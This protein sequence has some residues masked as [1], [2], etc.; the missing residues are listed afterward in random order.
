[1]HALSQQ[2]FM[3]LARKV[4]LRRHALQ[5][6]LVPYKKGSATI[7]LLFNSS[8]GQSTCAKSSRWY[9][10]IK[11]HMICGY[12]S[13][14]Q[15]PTQP[16][17]SMITTSESTYKNSAFASITT[18]TVDQDGILLEPCLSSIGDFNV[19]TRKISY[20]RLAFQKVLSA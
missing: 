15:P 3:G 16:R 10:C 14:A 2:P 7:D 19:V 6:Q 12:D 18:Q 8:F 11:G 4:L 5:A 17:S 1:M 13:N 9:Y 20:P